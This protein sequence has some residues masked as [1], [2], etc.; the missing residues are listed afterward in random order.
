[1]A[2]LLDRRGDGIQ[3]TD[4]VFKVAAHS[5]QEGVLH[6]L[7]Q[8]FAVDIRI[9]IPIARLHNSSRTGDLEAVR[10]LGLG[11]FKLDRLSW[12]NSTLVVSL[13][14]PCICCYA[15]PRAR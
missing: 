14:W 10:L 2:L 12:P 8:R 9:W 1:M 11:G 6:V 7:S 13:E 15:A 3:L 4:E 5:G